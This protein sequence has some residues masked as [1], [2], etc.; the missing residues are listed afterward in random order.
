MKELSLLYSVLGV[1]MMILTSSTMW[2]R[3]CRERDLNSHASKKAQDFKSCVSANS[4][5]PAKFSNYIAQTTFLQGFGG[6]DGIRTRD[7]GFADHGLNQ[8][9]YVTDTCEV[10]NILVYFTSTI[11]SKYFC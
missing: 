7:S 11:L 9:G 6:D 1:V 8:L 5:I 3:K 10:Y 2:I 4:T